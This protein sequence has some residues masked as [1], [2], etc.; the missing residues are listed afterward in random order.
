MLWCLGPCPIMGR[1][2]RVS[3]GGGSG[4]ELPG[5]T[6]I[7]ACFF[8]DHTLSLPI[9]LERMRF[10]IKRASLRARGKASS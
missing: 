9:P 5:R 2:E 1:L 7:S 4:R 6:H 3:Q 8:T 10:S